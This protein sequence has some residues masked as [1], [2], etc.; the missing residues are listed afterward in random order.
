M[1]ALVKVARARTGSGGMST[2]SNWSPQ[3]RGTPRQEAALSM[4]LS[5]PLLPAASVSSQESG[6]C[7][8]TCRTGA[9]SSPGHG[10]PRCLQ[11]RVQQQLHPPCRWQRRTTLHRGYVSTAYHVHHL[12]GRPAVLC[13][14]VKQRGSLNNRALFKVAPKQ[15]CRILLPAQKENWEDVS[16]TP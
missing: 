12:P 11:Q 16:E 8:V 3:Y 15:R 9:R 4:V 13:S 5:I 14:S 2:G 1:S 6:C 10:G 7:R